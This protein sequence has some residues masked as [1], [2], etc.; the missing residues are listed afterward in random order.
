MNAMGGRQGSFESWKEGEALLEHMSFPP[1]DE[2]LA[3]MPTLS[4]A[5]LPPKY[6]RSNAGRVFVNRSLRL[7]RISWVG[8]DMDYT[9]A[10]YKEP[11]FEALTYD[12]ALEHM[13]QI[14][15]PESIRGLKYDPHFPI[16]G[17][18]LD[19]QLGN[20]L[21]VDSFG[22]IILCV[23]GKKRWKKH[24]IYGSYPG[25]L[26]HNDE[27]GRRFYLLNTLFALPEACLYADLVDHL[28][29]HQQAKRRARTASQ[30]KAAASEGESESEPDATS[31]NETLHASDVELSFKN[32]FQDIRTTI[33]Y[34]HGEEELKKV[35][36]SDIAKY[37]HKNDKMPVL[38]DRLRKGGKKLFLLTNSEFN[39][40]NSVMTYLL[41]DA[42]P[43]YS[44]WRDYFDVIIVNAQKPRFFAEGTTLRMVDLRTGMLKVG[45]TTSFEPG[46]VYNGGSLEIFNRFTKT[47]S[48]NSVLYVGDH[49]FADIIVSKKAQGWRNLLVIR[50]LEEEL[51]SWKDNQEK[52]NKLLTLEW[53]RAEI[54]R[55][56]DSQST[57]PP[58]LSHLRKHTREATAELD[59]SFNKSFGSLFRSGSKQSFFSMQVQRYAD[60]YTAD[61]TN[62]LNY[63]LFY[64]F[65]APP[66]YLSH[67]REHVLF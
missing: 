3:N 26:I 40:T 32:L 37:I 16:R 21:K 29:H 59:K 43:E 53:V 46:Q 12:I 7:D 4:P 24:A 22:N 42:N 49:I 38:L 67:E 27:I 14:G 2:E 66:F 65:Y 23:H 13:V 35:V 54:F 30:K 52:Y 31:D 19:T 55:G 6:T 36:V 15:Y 17:L 56:L 5:Q 25:G 57:E 8:F 34:I 45:K 50:E 11:V 9:L 20:L 33:D 39:Y 44:S 48:P 41:G 18:F 47:T 63:P 64:T 58:D 1:T 61:Y 10:V 60:L 51:R 62:L 28:E